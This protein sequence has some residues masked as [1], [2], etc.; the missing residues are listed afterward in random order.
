MKIVFNTFFLFFYVALISMRRR[1]FDSRLHINN[2][3][4]IVRTG[5]YQMRYI[6]YTLNVYSLFERKKKEMNTLQRVINVYIFLSNVRFTRQKKGKI[7]TRYLTKHLIVEF[8]FGLR[9]I[10]NYS[11][12]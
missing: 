8:Y 12:W 9:V 1:P 7:I 4:D 11:R 5:S 3:Y 2:G 10:S 6:L